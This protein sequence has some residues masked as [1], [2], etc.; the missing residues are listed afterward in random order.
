MVEHKR[1]GRKPAPATEHEP[2]GSAALKLV[3][4]RFTR[5]QFARIKH[6]CTDEETSVRAMFLAA[7]AEYMQRKGYELGE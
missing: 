2:A 1:A 6:F 7:V 5:S 4:T 3:G